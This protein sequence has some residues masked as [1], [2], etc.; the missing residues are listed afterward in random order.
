MYPTRECYGILQQ[1]LYIR[2]WMNNEDVHRPDYSAKD[3]VT[4]ACRDEREDWM[5]AKVSEMCTQE[6]DGCHVEQRQSMAKSI[7]EVA[8]ERETE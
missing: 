1:A 3:T 7:L 2:T 6:K 4:D 8:S 5:H